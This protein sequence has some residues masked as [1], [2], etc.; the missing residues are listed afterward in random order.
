M[1]ED[2]IFKQFKKK[3]EESKDVNI[4]LNKVDVFYFTNSHEFSRNGFPLSR[5]E[6][7]IDKEKLLIKWWYEEPGVPEEGHFVISEILS[8]YET[9][10]KGG[11][12]LYLWEFFVCKK[13]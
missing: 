8:A 10:I 4:D 1:E 9:Y 2:L 5:Q 7:V 3:L 12:M 13:V 6:P 11:S